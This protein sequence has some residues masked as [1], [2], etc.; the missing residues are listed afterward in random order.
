MKRSPP[1][2]RPLCSSLISAEAHYNLGTVSE[3]KG[4]P[5]E[6]I[7]SYR[8][9]IGLKPDFAEAHGNLGNALSD[10]GQFDEAIAAYRQSI[11]FKPDYAEAHYNLSL[12]LLARQDF[13]RGWDEYEW[14]WKCQDF[15]SLQ[16]NFARP[17]WDGCPL[18]GRTILL[19]AEQGFGDAIQFI[20]YLPLVKERGG[21]IIVECQPELQR[22]FRTMA[23]TCQ[24]VASGQPLPAFDFHC[25]LLSLPRVFE[26]NLANIP[27]IVPYLRPEP[28]LVDAWS[29]TLGSGDGHLRVGL[30]WAGN[31]A[32]KG[33]RTRSLNLQQL[34]PFAAARGVKFYSLQKGP[35]GEQAKI[36]RR[37]WNWSISA[38]S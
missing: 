33:D 34:A 2:V 11:R 23:E 15:Q 32:F 21:K 1:I 13:Q 7:A 35:A 19:H 38:R 30:A 31:P 37:D 4:Q 5:D 27:N 9:A 36:R 3:A 24:V 28:A 25:P 6:A 14:R 26:T 8:Q 18:E 22:L 16:R 29:R 20:R 12:S 17:Q 10:L